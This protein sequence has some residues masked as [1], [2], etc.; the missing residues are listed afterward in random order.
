MDE[1]EEVRSRQAVMSHKEILQRF[2]KLFGRKMTAKERRTFFSAPDASPPKGKE[3]NQLILREG[4][5]FSQFCSLH[6]RSRKKKPAIICDYSW[7][8]LYKS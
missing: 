2:K 4:T 7:K 1:L 5:P 6:T 8:T 3:N